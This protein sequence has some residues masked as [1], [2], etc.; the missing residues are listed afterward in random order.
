MHRPD[1]TATAWSQCWLDLTALFV[2]QIEVQAT[3][4]T[5]LPKEGSQ[6]ADSSENGSQGDAKALGDG[7]QAGSTDFHD[8]SP[9]SPSGSGNQDTNKGGSSPAANAESTSGR[10]RDSSQASMSEDSSKSGSKSGGVRSADSKSSGSKQS[11]SSPSG[12]I[13]GHGTQEEYQEARLR[14]LSSGQGVL[15]SADNISLDEG[16]VG[17]LVTASF[18]DL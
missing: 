1:I 11:S 5:S 4:R 15:V 18:D 7:N 12:T 8:V 10:Q 2:V 17:S 14:F 13:G 9:S 16:Q 3:T 6:E